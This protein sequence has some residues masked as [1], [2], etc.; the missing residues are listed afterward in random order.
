MIVALLLV[1]LVH[2]SDINDTWPPRRR[3]PAEDGR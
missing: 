3:Q 1:D 2:F